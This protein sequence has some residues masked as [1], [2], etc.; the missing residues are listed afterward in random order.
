MAYQWDR[1]LETGVPAIDNQHK[2]LV[3]AVN[4]LLDACQSGKGTAEVA[5]TMDFLTGYTIKHFSD[6]EK[7]QKQYEYPDYAI[8]K[9]YHD[10]FKVTVGELT[11]RLIKDGPSE[12]L[13]NEV[14][15]SI[16]DWLVNHIK[17]DD[18]RMAAY[19]KTKIPA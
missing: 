19:V 10:A 8:H 6:E 9:R 16:G 12:T 4:S 13:I 2:Q 14:N 5:R 18:F 3:A 15:I 1:S 11:K 7:I 17:G